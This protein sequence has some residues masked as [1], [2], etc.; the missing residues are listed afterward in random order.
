MADQGQDQLERDLRSTEFQH[1]V[2]QRFWALLDRDLDIVCVKFF[3]RDDEAYVMRLECDGYGQQ[4]IGG[5]F[6]DPI[7]RACVSPAWPC[8]NQRF[9][10]WVKW[11]PGNL[12]ICWPG[13]R[14]G[15]VHHPDWASH[16]L[17]KRPPSPVV[18]YADFIRRLL[19]N[20]S[21]G[22]TGRAS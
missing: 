17:W 21:W 20:K 7:T 4:A 5:K 19:W 15:I 9:G 10:D 22:Y 14:Y 13:D 11:Q 2:E 18:M 6:V 12:F 1:G 16:Q 8:G 3:S